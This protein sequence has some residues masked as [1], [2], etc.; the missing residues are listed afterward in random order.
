MSL[1]LLVDAAIKEDMPE[2][3]ITTD[4][5]DQQPK[6]GVASLQAKEDLILSGTHV[7]SLVVSAFDPCAKIKWYFKDG[8]LVLNK[9]TICS[10]STNLIELLKAER[11]ALNF[12]S[13]LCGIATLTHCFVKKVQHTK[14]KI[15]DTRKT[16]PTLRDLEKQAVLHGGGQ[17]HRQNLSS[18]ILIKENHIYL[19]GGLSG[20]LSG[21]LKNAV[22][23]V[24]KNQ[25]KKNTDAPIEVEACNLDLVKT[26]VELK[27]HRILL[28][29]MDNKTLE[30]ALKLIPP[31]IETEA[32]GNMTLERV[33]DVAELGVNYISVGALTHSAPCADISLLFEK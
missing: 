9:Q 17:N 31:S 15:L 29:N 24:R 2:G 21:G 20:G 6:I 4:S 11:T 12:M 23:Q 14:T 8:D 32:S 28:D 18:G 5:L 10:I 26:A 3:D 27:V 16:T 22:A 30:E 19:M 25:L 33:C 13:H 1:N 7:F